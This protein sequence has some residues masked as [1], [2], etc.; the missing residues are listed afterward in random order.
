MPLWQR[1]DDDDHCRLYV[2]AIVS[3][4]S[5][6]GIARAAEVFTYPTIKLG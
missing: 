2:A 1:F 6:K 4:I 5:Q 3:Y